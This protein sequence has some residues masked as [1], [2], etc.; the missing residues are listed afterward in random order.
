MGL[1]VV[2]GLGLAFNGIIQ[3][4]NGPIKKRGGWRGGAVKVHFVGSA[5]T[6]RLEMSDNTLKQPIGLRSSD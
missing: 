2:Q 1:G 6:V 5:P 4:N 3:P